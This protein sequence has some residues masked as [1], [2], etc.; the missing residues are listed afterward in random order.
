MSRRKTTNVFS[1][2]VPGNECESIVINTAGYIVQHLHDIAEDQDQFFKLIATY[3]FELVELR[4]IL[5]PKNSGKKEATLKQQIRV[6]K[7]AYKKLFDYFQKQ[8]DERGKT[9]DESYQDID[10]SQDY[11]VVW[12]LGGGVDNERPRWRCNLVAYYPHPYDRSF[13]IDNSPMERKLEIIQQKI[14]NIHDLRSDESWANVSASTPKPKSS[15]RSH[16]L[17]RK[18]AVRVSAKKGTSVTELQTKLIELNEYELTVESLSESV[19]TSNFRVICEKWTKSCDL[20]ELSLWKNNDLVCRTWR[21]SIQNLALKNRLRKLITNLHSDTEKTEIVNKITEIYDNDNV[22]INVSSFVFPKQRNDTAKH[23]VVEISGKNTDC[24]VD[25]K[26]S[27]Y[28]SSRK[29]QIRPWRG[30]LPGFTKKSK[31]V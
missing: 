25:D 8:H 7:T 3:N 6:K 29:I 22:E 17:A 1:F 27:E 15:M 28:C 2:P 14:E 9:L 5:N 18:I 4:E 10:E 12:K 19:L 31:F 24:N 21:G 26:I 23:F 30:K 13:V 16:N 20:S 11:R